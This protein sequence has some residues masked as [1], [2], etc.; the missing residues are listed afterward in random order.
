MEEDRK[1]YKVLVKKPMGK[2]PLG[3]PRRRC[4]DWIR[5]DLGSLAGGNV[6]WI[7]LAQDRNRW[8]SVACPCEYGTELSSF[9]DTELVG[10]LVKERDYLEDVGANGTMIFKWISQKFEISL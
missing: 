2:R 8:R 10:W 5:M 9:G 1:V 6:E 4:E 7:L 3:R